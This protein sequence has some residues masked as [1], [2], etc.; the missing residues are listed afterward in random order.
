MTA[1][2]KHHSKKGELVYH[3]KMIREHISHG[4]FQM[5]LTILSEQL[6]LFPYD[7]ILLGLLGKIYFLLGDYQEALDVYKNIDE[8]RVFMK[9]ILANY[10]LHNKEE[11]YRLYLKY[12]K[13]PVEVPEDY[14]IRYQI[15][16]L[17]MIK[18]FEPEKLIYEP[19]SFYLYRQIKE[20]DRIE[21]INHVLDRHVEEMEDKTIFNPDLDII[22]LFDKY[23]QVIEE[24]KDKSKINKG[25]EGYLFYY[26]NAGRFVDSDTNNLD[27]IYV[28]TILDTNH[29]VTMCPVKQRGYM[30]VINVIEDKEEEKEDVKVLSRIDTFNNKYKIEE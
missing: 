26:P 27:Y 20:Y 23:E 17:Y 8:D 11:L 10:K 3:T 9:V 25:Q 4:K 7:P 1:R 5:A 13:N 15:I 2:I 22:E 6:K 30:K 18:M 29:I 14:D 21:A 19:S 28:G 16:K 24:N 12:I